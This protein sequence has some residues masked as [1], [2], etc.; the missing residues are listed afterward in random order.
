MMMHMHKRKNSYHI[1]TLVKRLSK[2]YNGRDL[3]FSLPKGINIRN[4]VL[5]ENVQCVSF[6]IYIFLFRGGTAQWNGYYGEGSGV[7]WLDNVHCIGNEV[8]ISA[9]GH[10]GWG[11]SN[12][13][14]REDAGIQCYN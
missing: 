9:C 5:K 2:R 12:C 3:F 6:Y 10:L 8:G 7:I 11:M 14:H 4:H 1:P 13:V